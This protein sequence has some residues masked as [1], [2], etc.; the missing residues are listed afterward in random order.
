MKLLKHFLA[1]NLFCLL[2]LANACNESTKKAEEEIVKDEKGQLRAPAYPL[3]THNPY[4]SLWAMGDEL[5]GQPTQHWTGADQSLLGILKLDNKYYRFIGAATKN[6]K[7]LLPATDEQHYEVAYTESKPEGSWTIEKFDD[8]SWEKGKAP[9]SDD[10]TQGQTLWKSDDLWYRRTFNLEDA[11][12]K[13][14]YL[15]IRHDDNVTAY[16]NGEEIF[17][18]DG[19]QDSFKFIPIEE[20]VIKKLKKTGNVLAIHIRNTGGGQWLDAGLVTDAP[21]M[22]NIEIIKAEQTSVTSNA[23]QTIYTFNCEGTALTATFT[24]PLFLDDLDLLARP[25]SYLSV[26]VKFED[27]KQHETQLYLGAATAFAV[28]TPNQEVEV[29]TMNVPGMKVLKAGTTSQPVLE[30]KGDILRIDW[31]Y[32]YM[33]ATSGNT[34]TSVSSINEV[35]GAFTGNN[36]QINETKSSG[37]NL[38]LNTVTDYGS[39]SKNINQ[40][41]MLGYDELYSINYFGDQLKPWWKK[42]GNEMVQLLETAKNDYTSIIDRV[43]TF[44]KQIY[45]D[46]QKAGGSAYADICVLAYRQSIAA[47]TLVEAPNGNLLWLSKENNS[48][49]SINTVDLTYPSAPLFLL[50]NP[51][52]QKGQMNGIFY[53]SESGKWKKPFAAH[54][55]G[56]YPIATGQTYGEDMPIEE[57]GNMVILT[58]AI[59]QQEGNADYAKAHWETLSIWSEYLLRE[60]F[61]PANQLSTDDFSGHLARNANLSIKA[62]LAIASYG[63]LAGM[64]ND[65]ETEK[66]Y[67]DAA[68]NMAKKWVELAKDGDHYTLAFEQPGTWSQKYNL[69]WDSILDLNIFPKEVAEQEINFY[70]TKQNKYGLPLDSRESYS[71]SDWILWTAT[72]TET[73]EDFKAIVE[74]VWHFANDTPDR[75]PLSD[76][77]WTIDGKQ[78]GFKARSVVA[79]YYLKM[80]KEKM[81]E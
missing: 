4:F 44:D 60:G 26:D 13:S 23:M 76:W 42:D 47:H 64:L 30:K 69:V 74:P 54:D 57:A 48:N 46:A 24:S 20:S 65:V 8:Q 22:H 2:F 33:A 45:S 14:L 10:T 67:I 78:R 9:F 15:K 32:F 27:G 16:I 17:K 1:L 19:W 5:N 29:E 77:H 3:I 49:G 28:N 50:Y 25:V 34:T 79:G 59:A 72:L 51:E 40:V 56:T 39:T 66:K 35:M 61:D 43:K 41:Y 38:M 68:K 36:S 12:L 21:E 75:V 53:Y 37:R 6:Y 71:K 52:L 31:G 63:K 62:I 73:E 18:A 70:L 55:L 81:S 11:N 58:L 80:L 7:T